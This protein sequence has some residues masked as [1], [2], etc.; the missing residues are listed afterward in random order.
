MWRNT[1]E[2]GGTKTEEGRAS[3]EGQNFVV[4]TPGGTKFRGARLSRMACRAGLEAAVAS[5]AELHGRRNTGQPIAPLLGSC[6][7]R[8]PDWVS[9]F[10]TKL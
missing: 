3:L 7:T 5:S 1:R 8:C 9:G 6:T 10:S 4:R 2:T